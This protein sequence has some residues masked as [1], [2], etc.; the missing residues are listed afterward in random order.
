MSARVRRRRYLRAWQLPALLAGALGLLTSCGSGSGTSSTG[1]T[2]P[3]GGSGTS[4][5]TPVNNIQPVQVALGPTGNDVNELQT[6]VTICVPGTSSCQTIS[7]VLLDTGSTGLRLFSSVVTLALPRVNDA[8]GNPLGNCTQ[9]VSNTYAWGPVAKAEVQLAG[10]VASSVPMQLID[11]PGFAAAPSSCQT[12]G[13]ALTIDQLGAN[14]ILGVGLFQQDCGSACTAT[15]GP[16]IY[17][18]CP[19]SGCVPEELA[20]NQQIQNPIGLFPQDNNGLVLTLPALDPGGNQAVSGSLTFGIGTQSNNALSA[21]QIYTADANGDFSVTFNGQTYSASFLD[22]GSNGLF[23]LNSA[24]LG[25]PVCSNDNSFYC[26]S[27]TQAYSAITTGANGVAGTIA[28]TIANAD[29]LFNT[30][31]TAFNDLG[32]PNVGGFDLGLPFFFGRNVYLAIQGASTSAGPG[33]YWAY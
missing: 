25:I 8:S 23:L 3:G 7:N 27:T 31:N 6:N 20:L 16:A 30:G 22:T 28:L 10:E 9:F 14:G 18:G 21:V 24:T 12:G 13:S 2:T 29:T 15:T 33:P 19:S 4:T 11:V 26:P 5:P 32:G 1:S 17:Y